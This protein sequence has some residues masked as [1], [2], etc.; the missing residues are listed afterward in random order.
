MNSTLSFAAE[1]MGGALHGADRSFDGISIDSR[2]IRKDELF[3]ALSGPN[4][5][6]G[7]FVSAAAGKGAAGAVVTTPVVASMTKRPPTSSNSNRSRACA[8]FSSPSRRPSARPR[9]RT[10]RPADPT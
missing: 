6:G 3:I 7:E 1:A 9:C 4:F 8:G 5:D 2:S 10:S